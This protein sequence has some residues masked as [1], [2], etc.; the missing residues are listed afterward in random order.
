MSGGFERAG[1]VASPLGQAEAALALGRPRPPER[2]E[3]REAPET[4]QLAGELLGRVVAAL[5]ASVAV[6]RD[7][8][9]S[10]HG[11][12]LD[13]NRDDVCRLMGEG[14]LTAFLPGRNERPNGS[15]VGDGGACEGEREPPPRALEA[16]QDR[17]GGGRATARAPRSTKPR[18]VGTAC[19]TERETVASAD[20]AAPRKQQIQK[21]IPSTVCATSALVG[22]E[23][24]PKVELA[25]ERVRAPSRKA[26][27]GSHAVVGVE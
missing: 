5:H 8:G 15:L 4:T 21:H 25:L 23:S 2:A 20:D 18:Q 22:D 19:A 1:H 3:Q 12:S 24:V 14:S 26:E 13:A 7:E 17:P 10:R 27:P 6:R 11:G 16:A 9:K